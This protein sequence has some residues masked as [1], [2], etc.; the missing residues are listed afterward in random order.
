MSIFIGFI[1]LFALILVNVPIAVAIGLVAITGMVLDN[2]FVSVYNAALTLFDG[3][4]NFPLIAIPLFILAG[5]L[6]NTTSISRRLIDFCLA[7]VGF[8]RGG[9]AMVNVTVSLFFA[10]ISGS[11]V[12]DVAATGS[13]LIPAMKKRGFTPQF[14]AA[15]TSST[16][17]LAIIIPPSIPM[18]LYG[19]LSDTSIVQLFIAGVIP[20]LIGASLMFLVCYRYALKY[21]IPKEV[22]FSL[23]NLMRSGKEAGW[24]LLLPVIIL[25]GIFGGLVTATEG[26]G[27]AVVAALVIGVFIYRDLEMSQLHEALTE[28]VIQTATVMLLVATSAVLGLHLTETELP[29]KLTIA[30]TQITTDPILVLI[31]INIMLFVLGMFLH[32]AAAIILTV[33][34]LMPLVNQVG[35]D[36]VHFGIILTL[37]I[38]LGQQT[39]PVASVL[40]TSCAI[41]KTDIWSA[42][43]ANIPLIGVLLFVLLLVS[44]VPAIPLM[45]VEMFYR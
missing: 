3:A 23:A 15:L 33:P 41:A 37:N 9:L 34:I 21:G 31:I 16:A 6:M 38:A 2:G 7:L 36:P 22:A 17:S 25:G 1:V 35:I 19:A 20:G 5:C 26:A 14:S 4:T 40:A 27:L 44:Y 8:I 43:R 24:A 45:L 32:G 11:A 10:E 29:Q 18:I 13:V 39:P 12:A 28:G 42:T 30:V